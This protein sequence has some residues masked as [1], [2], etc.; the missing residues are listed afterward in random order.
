MVAFLNMGGYA[1]FVWGSYFI[2]LLL[3]S[4]L[5]VRSVKAF[6]SL[7]SKEQSVSSKQ[8]ASGTVRAK[9]LA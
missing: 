6:K 2:A 8:E 1:V 7:Q 4:I 5:Y 9:S 3:V